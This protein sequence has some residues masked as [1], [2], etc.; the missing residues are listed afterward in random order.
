ML[1]LLRPSTTSSTTLGTFT[2]FARL[3]VK[4]LNIYPMTPGQ[5]NIAGIMIKFAANLPQFAANLPQFAANLLQFAANLPQFAANL[6]Q[7]AA[8][9]P[10]F[11]ANL[12]CGRMSPPSEQDV[13]QTTPLLPALAPQQR[14]GASNRAGRSAAAHPTPCLPASPYRVDGSRLAGVLPPTLT[15][16]ANVTRT[17]APSWTAIRVGVSNDS[18]SI[19]DFMSLYDICVAA[20][21]AARVS[22]CHSTG[23]Q[24]VTIFFCRLPTTTTAV[25]VRKWRRH[26]QRCRLSLK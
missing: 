21:L 7:F 16:P 24:D 8:N 4:R 20:G 10:Q 14:D 9:L 23:N 26:H 18:P 6:P 2:R 1:F 22:V 3:N 25:N 15:Q 19:L 17:V 5:L 13:T 11:A 12:P